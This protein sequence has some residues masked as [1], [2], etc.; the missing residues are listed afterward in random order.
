MTIYDDLP[1]TFPAPGMSRFQYYQMVSQTIK[2]L[3]TRVQ[4]EETEIGGGGSTDPETVR[5]VIGASLVGGTGIS[6]TPND[7]S[8]TITIAYTGS[9]GSG[10]TG[11]A[12]G[13]VF[14][15]DQ[16]VFG[17]PLSD[18]A[19]WGTTLPD[20][21][22]SW[23]TLLTYAH[24]NDLKVYLRPDRAYDARGMQSV[25]QNVRIIGGGTLVGRAAEKAEGYWGSIRHNPET[26]NFG[27]GVASFALVTLPN[28]TGTPSAAEVNHQITLSSSSNLNKF[29][30]GDVWR[31]TSNNRYAWDTGAGGNV[32]RAEQIDILGVLFP[33]TSNTAEEGDTIVGAISGATG[34]VGSR[35]G[36][37]YLVLKSHT[38]T[39]TASETYTVGGSSKGTMAGAGKVLVRGQ[40]DDTLYSGT[41]TLAK[42]RSDLEVEMDVVFDVVGDPEQ[43]VGDTLRQ[44][45]LTLWGLVRPQIKVKARNG[46]GPLVYVGSCDRPYIHLDVWDHINNASETSNAVLFEGGYGYGIEV[47]GS[48]RGGIYR[49]SGTK[50]RHW[51]TTNPLVRTSYPTANDAIYYFTGMQRRNDV[52]ADVFASYA[53]ALDNHI[54]AAD[55]YYHDSTITLAGISGGRHFAGREGVQNRS[56]NSVY[57]RV[58]VIGPMSNG[59]NDLSQN[60]DWEVPSV[61]RIIDSRFEGML[62]GGFHMESTPLAAN[63]LSIERTLFAMTKLPAA[64]VGE[65]GSVGINMAAGNARFKDVIVKDASYAAIN[66]RSG[67]SGAVMMFDD[68]R[69]DIADG[70]FTAPFMIRL[71][72]SGL[73][74]WLNDIGAIENGTTWATNRG[75]VHVVSGSPTI[76]RTARPFSFGNATALPV[77]TSGSATNTLAVIDG[78]T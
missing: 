66:V 53:A 14:A 55:T 20:N 43:T 12:F 47:V 59:F 50:M 11:A 54:G 35:L 62:V 39:F 48:T 4:T 36:S 52:S 75:A 49:G 61:T 5:D 17:R 76:R 57:E 26:A 71:A 73:T 28:N 77:L 3:D 70:G 29:R 51:F 25:N 16:G 9:G 78:Y 69:F 2:D 33:T 32:W 42:M 68:F 74:V 8:D 1:T 31:I 18:R 23:T 22:S 41:I 45:F 44:N 46:W 7:G 60:K 6:V 72:S 19:N 64:T 13:I 65:G 15:E 40:M 27:I 30:D 58:R 67:L 38:G 56:A 10:I 24:N 21:S 63:S 34:V 37:S